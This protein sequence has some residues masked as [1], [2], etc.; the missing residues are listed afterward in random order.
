MRGELKL[1]DKQR[2]WLELITTTNLLWL[3]RR[4]D[5][6]TIQRIMTILSLGHYDYFDQIMLNEIREEWIKDWKYY[7]LD[8]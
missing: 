3:K 2:M 5:P 7:S 4:Y 1:N 6:L 8:N